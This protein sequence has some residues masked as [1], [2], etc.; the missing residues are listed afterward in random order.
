MKKL[1][2]SLA[3][4]VAAMC[5]QAASVAVPATVSVSGASGSTSFWVTPDYTGDLAA[6]V[7]SG[8]SGL[9]VRNNSTVSKWP[10]RVLAVDAGSSYS[11]LVSWKN[12]AAPTT[13][14]I[15]FSQSVGGP[16]I[17]STIVTVTP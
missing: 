13:W 2:V 12:V 6:F 16:P 3:L 15:C 11:A 8:P 1:F 7:C 4:A 17:G 10:T 14:T 9:A 5:A